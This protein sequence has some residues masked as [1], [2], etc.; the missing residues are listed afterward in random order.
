MYY[1][2]SIKRQEGI[3]KALCCELPISQ[4]SANSYETLKE[5]MVDELNIYLSDKT[6]KIFL[7]E[8]YPEF[9]NG[10]IQRIGI[11][12]YLAFSV[13]LRYTRDKNG[14]TQKTAAKK[15]GYTSTW[16]YQRL[17]QNANPCISTIKKV[18]EL[19]P[20]YPIH[21]LFKR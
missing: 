21:H 9:L 7:P 14:I 20:D 11:S 19:F 12:H 16:A 18:I 8:E 5:M 4:V 1:H 13:L 10:N 2:F 6:K 3:Y 17:E 15:M